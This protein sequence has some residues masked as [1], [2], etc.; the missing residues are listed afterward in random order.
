MIRTISTFAAVW[1][2]FVLSDCGSVALANEPPSV[3][4]Y[5]I[6]GTTRYP[7]DFVDANTEA[8]VVVVLDD[9]CPVVQQLAPTLVALHEKYNG[10]E[11]DRAGQ[12]KPAA[13]FPE[14]KYPGDRV[15]FLGVYIKHDMG[16]KRMAAHAAAVRIPFRVVH[17]TGKQLIQQLGLTRLSEAAVLTPDWQV[18]YRGPVDDQHAQGARKPKANQHYVVDAVDAI[19]A[20]EPVQVTQRPPVGCKISFAEP[21]RVETALT[22]HKDVEPLLQKHCQACHREGEVGPLNLLTY[23]DVMAYAGMVEEVILHERMPPFPGETTRSF[24]ADERLTEDER[25]TLLEWLRSD[26]RQGD[27]ADAPPPRQ[28][29]SRDHWNIGE[30]D[31]VFKMPEPLEIPATGILNY[32]Y[33]PVPVNGGK[34]FAE[35]RWIEAIETHPG[36][37]KVVHHVQVHEYFGPVD[38]EPTALDQILIYGLGIET[39]RLL[40]GYTPGNEEGNQLRLER[41]LPPGSEGKTAGIRLSKGANLM[42]EVHYT[43]N[44]TATTDQS[45]VAIK[46]ADKK[47]DVELDSWFPFR[48]RADLIVPANLQHHSAQDLYHFGR[49]TDGKPVLLHALR[50]HMHSRGKSFRVEIVDPRGLSQTVLRDHS[51]HSLVRGEPILT[52]PVWDFDWQRFYQFEEPILIRPNEALLATA[53]WDNTR[54]NPRNPDPQDNAPWGQQT[55]QEMFNTLL[56]FEVLEPDDPRAQPT[57]RREV[58]RKAR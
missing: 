33:I 8:I 24:A 39:A 23:K 27:P 16:A 14:G 55:T 50:P 13:G 31:L 21:A 26:R 30:P 1:A 25:N 3:E 18:R 34:G 10:F 58:A 6:F 7:A 42:F 17:D 45:E 41:Y 47:P 56:L 46:F 40:G 38:R 48:S 28:F 35:D 44:G 37:P 53:Y 49:A 9:R 15:K 11:K 19:L 4:L 43:T 20:G 32:F 2:L 52:V 29:G 51:Q 54:H 5:D 22:Y 36:D 57:E 12:P